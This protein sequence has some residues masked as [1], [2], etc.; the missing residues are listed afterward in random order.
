MHT[1]RLQPEMHAERA[2]AALAALHAA[3]PK[4]LRYV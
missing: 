4:F 1:W 3:A 2:I